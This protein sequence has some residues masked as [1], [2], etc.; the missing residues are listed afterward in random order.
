MRLVRVGRIASKRKK[1]APDDIMKTRGYAETRD[2]HG[3]STTTSAVVPAHF[4]MEF[5]VG[6]PQ[7]RHKAK[8]VSP[9]SEL[10]R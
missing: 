9:L 7:A 2:E 8:R 5:L 4:S 3:G 1:P 10:T 6:L